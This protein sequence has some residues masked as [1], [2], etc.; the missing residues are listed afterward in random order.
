MRRRLAWSIRRAMVAV[1]RR[2]PVETE[3]GGL[4]AFAPAS[5]ARRAPCMSDRRKGLRTMTNW[6]SFFVRYRLVIVAA[7][8]LGLLA[9][10]GYCWLRPAE[11]IGTTRL[12]FST[13]AV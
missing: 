4:I 1:H 13:G 6:I 7:T 11:Y 2:R 8:V 3:D 5:D 9:S 12:F 10:L